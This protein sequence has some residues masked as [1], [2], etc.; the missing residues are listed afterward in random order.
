MTL[1]AMQP[2]LALTTM[3][4]LPQHR[5]IYFGWTETARGRPFSAFDSATLTLLSHDYRYAAARF[6]WGTALVLILPRLERRY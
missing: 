4:D 1:V 6:T 2:M 5:G 3:C